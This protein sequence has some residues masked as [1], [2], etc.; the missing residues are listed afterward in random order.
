MYNI[1]VGFII[2]LS[3]SA[4][5]HLPGIVYTGVFIA[6]CRIYPAFPRNITWMSNNL[7]GSY[8]RSAGMA[9]LLDPT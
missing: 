9:I 3:A 4:H 5:C 1:L 7:V 6:A 2:A 8:K